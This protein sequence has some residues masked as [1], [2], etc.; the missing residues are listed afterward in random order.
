MEAQITDEQLGEAVLK[1][2]QY[3]VYPDLE[4][5]ISAD[6]PDSALP[7]VLEILN[8]ARNDIKVATYLVNETR[9]IANLLI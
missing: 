9:R 6:V 5:V 8:N 2:V 1:S 7:A 3:G 4:E